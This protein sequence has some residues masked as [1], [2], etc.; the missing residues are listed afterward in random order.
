MMKAKDNR[1][2]FA[3][4]I[5]IGGNLTLESY[6]DPW[7]IDLVPEEHF[8]FLRSCV[9][10]FETETHIFTHANYDPFLPFALQSSD[11]LRWTSL[12][13]HLP[14]PHESGKTVGVGH[15]PHRNVM[16][17]GHLICI[18]TGCGFDGRLTALD[19][20]TGQQWRTGDVSGWKSST[21]IQSRSGRSS[22]DGQLRPK[23][24]GPLHLDGSPPG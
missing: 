14:G 7:N 12:R 10:F 22:S 4:W 24:L 19:V 16:D 5:G 8:Q 21:S 23:F 20:D 13:D 1:G 17:L 9:P 11:R 3:A 6:G 18:D 2:D 15:T